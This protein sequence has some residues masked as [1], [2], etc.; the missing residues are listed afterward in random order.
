LPTTISHKGSLDLNASQKAAIHYINGPLLVLAGAGS[1][2][3]AVITHKIATLIRE[4]DYAPAQI[5]AVTFTNKAA[6]EM[7]TRLNDLLDGARTKGLTVGT[8]HAL[9]LAILRE[10]LEVLGFRPGFSIYDA[11]DSRAL[12][13][14]LLGT[15]TREARAGRTRA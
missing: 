14:R 5:V 15:A 7:K 8:F 1:G 13:A 6:R 11:E 12:V 10:H 4:Y 2:K 3:T 9:G